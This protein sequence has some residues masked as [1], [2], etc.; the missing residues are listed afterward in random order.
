MNKMNFLYKHQFAT[1]AA[2]LL[3]LWLTRYVATGNL[4]YLFLLWNLFLAAIPLLMAGLAQAR[5]YKGWRLMLSSVV[6]L[7]F[8]PNAPYLITDLYHLD[9]LAPAAP[10]LWYDPLMVFVA[11][12][13]GV[14]MGFMSLGIMEKLWQPMLWQHWFPQCSTRTRVFWRQ[15]VLVGIFLATGFGLFAGRVLRWNSWD[16]ISQPV[17][18]LKS[19]ALQVWFPL[20]HINTWSFTILY[21]LV[22][23]VLY[24]F[25]GRKPR[26]VKLAATA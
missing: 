18:L 8:F 5:R 1:C 10:Q 4:R 12:Y 7:L 22:L 15:G 3:L 26:G 6:W 16:V 13:T 25:S 2:L 17:G 24:Q 14:K 21:A 9:H 19:L 23:F 20:Q 11:A